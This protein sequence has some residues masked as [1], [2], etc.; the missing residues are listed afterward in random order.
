[1]MQDSPITD[2]VS[3]ACGDVLFESRA[4]GVGIKARSSA[5]A[6]WLS[7]RFLRTLHSCHFFSGILPCP[8]CSATPCRNPGDWFDYTPVCI[9]HVVT[10][11]GTLQELR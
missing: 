1:M 5:P 8:L 6:P 11:K 7:M 10:Y 9:L 3:S 4:G 2:V